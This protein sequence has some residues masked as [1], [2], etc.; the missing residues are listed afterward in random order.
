MTK[1]CDDPY[2]AAT[3]RQHA[4]VQQEVN[5]KWGSYRQARDGEPADRRLPDPSD[6]CWDRMMLIL[7][8]TTAGLAALGAYV[9]QLL[10]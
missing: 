10:S 4:R 2:I 7:I 8:P 6:S 9:A 1:K 5:E 3:H